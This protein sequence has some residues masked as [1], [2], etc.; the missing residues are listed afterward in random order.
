MFHP[1]ERLLRPKEN[2]ADLPFVTSINEAT[3]LS[4]LQD[5]KDTMEKNEVDVVRQWMKFNKGLNE[6]EGEP[7]VTWI[8]EVYSHIESICETV[9][10]NLENVS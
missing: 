5:T 2:D 3:V 6:R 4:T 1:V 9:E 8:N 7:Y 10:E